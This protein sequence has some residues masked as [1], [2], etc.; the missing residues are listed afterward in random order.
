MQRAVQWPSLGEGP[1]ETNHAVF[2]LLFGH[3]LHSNLFVMDSS[4]WIFVV[5]T[6]SYD[7]LVFTGIYLH[8]YI[9]RLKS[10]ILL[11]F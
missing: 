11:F 3:L 9:F 8:D 5:L 1:N 6:S 10:S 7:L 2:L 4:S